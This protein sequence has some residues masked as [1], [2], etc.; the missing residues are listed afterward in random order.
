MVENGSTQTHVTRRDDGTGVGDVTQGRSLSHPK[1]HALTPDVGAI[2]KSLQHRE[3]SGR[4]S[5]RSDQFKAA[6]VNPVFGNG[7]HLFVA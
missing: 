1:S 5:K 6:L 7:S 4:N 2:Q 3:G